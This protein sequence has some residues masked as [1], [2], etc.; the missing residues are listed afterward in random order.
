[1]ITLTPLGEKIMR[2]GGSFRLAWP[3]TSGVG[4]TGGTDFL[5]DMGFDPELYSML[6]DLRTRIANNESVP[7]Y[8]VFSNKTLEALARYRPKT[9]EEGKA[10][11]GIGEAKAQRYLQAFLDVIHTWTSSRK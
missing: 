1:L 10:V 3:S 4:G 11:P 7:S 9:I 5:P 2:G 8:V 6:R